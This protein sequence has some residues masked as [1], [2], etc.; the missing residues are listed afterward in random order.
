MKAGFAGN[1]PFQSW[2]AIRSE[3]GLEIHEAEGET[4]ADWVPEMLSKVS[5]LFYCQKQAQLIFND[6][7]NNNPIKKVPGTRR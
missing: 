3:K 7:P 1:M 2:D 5:A 6:I 4:A